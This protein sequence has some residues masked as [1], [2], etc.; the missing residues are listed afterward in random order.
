MPGG[1]IDDSGF[2]ALQAEDLI[3]GGDVRGVAVLVAGLR[4]ANTWPRREP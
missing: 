2:V 4:L 1:V 3:A